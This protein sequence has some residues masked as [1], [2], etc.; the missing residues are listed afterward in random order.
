M[1]NWDD[2]PVI[3]LDIGEAF[4]AGSGGYV[5]SHLNNNTYTNTLQVISRD[6]YIIR[7]MLLSIMEYYL[8]ILTQTNRIYAIH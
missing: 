6:C 4:G 2:H 7:S 5:V 3:T 1:H 8:M